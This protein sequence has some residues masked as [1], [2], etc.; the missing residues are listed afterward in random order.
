M[1]CRALGRASGLM[2]FL[3]QRPRVSRELP[4]PPQSHAPASELAEAAADFGVP[5]RVIEPVFRLPRV[6]LAE[7]L[8]AFAADLSIAKSSRFFP[9]LIW[10]AIHLGIAPRPAHV[11]D[12]FFGL[13]YLGGTLRPFILLT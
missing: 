2:Q 4:N 3:S 1:S 6:F 7:P 11:S 12:E 13:R 10:A 9:A 5:F 8:F